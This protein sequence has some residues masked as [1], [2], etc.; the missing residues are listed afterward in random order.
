MRM[1]DS[2]HIAAA[3]RPATPPHLTTFDDILTPFTLVRRR[4]LDDL[5]VDLAYAALDVYTEVDIRFAVGVVDVRVAHLLE[6]FGVDPTDST[7]GFRLDPYLAGQ[8]H[9]GLAY[10]TPYAGVE[11][12][13][14]VARE[15][16]RGLART[17]LKIYSL[18]GE[19]VQIQVALSRAD[20]HHEIGRYLVVQ[21]NVPLVARFRAEVGALGLPASRRARPPHRSRR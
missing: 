5:Q 17:H 8:Q 6:P 20:L 11:A 21:A 10:P 13:R 3:N 19:A 12:L 2:T 15:I 16:H 9:R 1:N 7:F 4:S 14:V 18:K